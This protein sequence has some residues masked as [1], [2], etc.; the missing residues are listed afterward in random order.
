MRDV[1]ADTPVH[2]VKGTAL[3]RR[4]RRGPARRV[5]CALSPLHQS[6]RLKQTNVVAGFNAAAA[7]AVERALFVAVA[8]V[9][10]L[11]SSHGLFHSHFAEAITHSAREGECPT[12]V[13]LLGVQRGAV[14]LGTAVVKEEGLAAVAA[15]DAA[16]VASAAAFLRRGRR[17]RA[18]PSGG[19]ALG[20][21]GR[22][23]TGAHSEVLPRCRERRHT[24]TSHSCFAGA[25]LAFGKG[26][27]ACSRSGDGAG[28]RSCTSDDSKRC[29]VIHAA[30]SIA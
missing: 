26:R 23:I 20:G 7:Q 9:R 11:G 13:D 8:E 4:G 3:S 19:N 12:S 24:G 15:V 16:L 17:Q 14:A 18:L 29:R 5:G 27:A 10:R 1:F 25:V 2:V 28:A 22:R 30:S 6:T 21:R